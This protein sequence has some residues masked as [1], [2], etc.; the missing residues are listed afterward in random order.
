MED[1]TAV[2]SSLA[3]YSGAI[4]S[5]VAYRT[6]YGRMSVLLKSCTEGDND[7]SENYRYGAAE[8]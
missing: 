6:I 1:W 2:G 5:I 7:C 8:Y 3:F 4:E